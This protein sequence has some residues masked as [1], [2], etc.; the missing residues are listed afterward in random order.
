ME[1]FYGTMGFGPNAASYTVSDEVAWNEGG[2]PYARKRRFEVQGRLFVDG[3]ADASAKINALR[4]ALD[5]QFLDLV[6]RHDDGTASADVLTNTGSSTG[7]RSLGASFPEAEGPEYATIRTFRC[8]FEAEYP[9]SGTAGLLLSF[10]ETLTFRGGGAVYVVLP[11]ISGGAQRQLVYP[12]GGTAYEATQEGEAVGYLDWPVI[13]GPLFPDA[14]KQAPEVSRASP[15]RVGAGYQ[16][17]A[18]RWSYAYESTVPLVGTPN[19]WL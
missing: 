7:V 6:F 8:A 18:T 10:R 3:Q 19:L 2:Q 1:L 4:N 12:A 5:V 11:A 16:E 9:L 14:L 17:Y 13:P 15:K